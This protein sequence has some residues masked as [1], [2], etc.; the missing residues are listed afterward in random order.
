M[1][2]RQVDSLLKMYGPYLDDVETIGN[3]NEVFGTQFGKLSRSYKSHK[4]PP[5]SRGSHPPPGSA[6]TV[7]HLT[8]SQGS[9]SASSSRSD[10]SSFKSSSVNSV[11]SSGNYTGFRMMEIN[12]SQASR[13]Q[14][15]SQ[16]TDRKPAASRGWATWEGSAPRENS[17]KAAEIKQGDTVYVAFAE[18]PGKFWCQPAVSSDL[19]SSMAEKLNGEYSNLGRNESFLQSPTTGQLCCALYTEDNSWYR[20]K[21][22]EVTDMNARVFF[23]D[24]GN[25][26]TV[27]M[28]TLKQLREKYTQLPCQAVQCSLANVTPTDGNW[29]SAACDRFSKL[30]AD[31]ELQVQTMVRKGETHYVE[32]G[33]VGRRGNIGQAL[34]Q[35][36][37]A[38][39]RSGS[40]SQDSS[41][42]PLPSSAKF[43]RVILTPGET[44]D[45]NV[46][47]VVD[48]QNFFCQLT[49]NSSPLEDVMHTIARDLSRH[50]VAIKRIVR[51]RIGQI[52]GAKYEAENKWYRAEVVATEGSQVKVC[53]CTCN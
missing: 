40:C 42:S 26:E 1:M 10:V 8:K 15:V 5:S 44:A 19:L 37:F 43:D 48:P 36:G 53:I 31:K 14:R 27:S 13:G 45:V 49:K 29:S 12:N 34:I 50:D 7:R 17:I 39:S 21:I 24:Y 47:Y 38:V 3:I 23:V 25:Q 2:H 33:E 20:A 35:I 16:A 52:C 30:Y 4:P 28:G 32:L 6:K 18:S 51:P 41:S 9:G 11:P 22:L 46:V